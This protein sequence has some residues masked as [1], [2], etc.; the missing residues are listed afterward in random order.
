M[1]PS[2]GCNLRGEGCSPTGAHPALKLAETSHEPP[3]TTSHLL[4]W[5][6][7]PPPSALPSPL[8]SFCITV[9]HPY[10]MS[11]SHPLKLL[12][13]KPQG[14]FQD[15]DEVSTKPLS[16][17][18]QQGG[19]FPHNTLAPSLVLAGTPQAQQTPVQSLCSAAFCSAQGCHKII[20]VGKDH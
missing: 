16:S 14:S 3:S 13:P 11:P 10:R 18:V 17:L 2:G 5:S 4:L 19:A 6:T 1:S 12:S 7:H 15:H 8:L 9:P 20:K